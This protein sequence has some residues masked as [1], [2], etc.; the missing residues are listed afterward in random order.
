MYVFDAL[1]TVW[2]PSEYT[3]HDMEGT[4]ETVAHLALMPLLVGK[5]VPASDPRQST[6]VTSQLAAT[7]TLPT[8]LAPQVA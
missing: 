4:I 3:E 8:P 1:G 6:W 2:T 5:E 7:P